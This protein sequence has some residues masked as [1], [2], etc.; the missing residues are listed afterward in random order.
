[1]NT[2][3]ITAALIFVFSQS[4]AATDQQ[5]IER[6]KAELSNKNFRLTPEE[7][8]LSKDI[9]VA[10]VKASRCLKIA[11]SEVESGKS[12][13]KVESWCMKHYPEPGAGSDAP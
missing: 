12:H 7:K 3:Y 9:G 10:G 1:M 11:V 6:A 4:Y 8:T 5:L 2:R 13:P